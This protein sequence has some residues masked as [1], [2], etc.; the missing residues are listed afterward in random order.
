VQTI[1]LPPRTILAFNG[2]DFGKAILETI[3]FIKSH[4]EQL[5]NNR[6]IS[7]SSE[8]PTLWEAEHGY[9]DFALTLAKD[10]S[11]SNGAYLWEAEDA[12]GEKSNGTGKVRYALDVKETGSYIL[13]GRFLSPTSDDDSFFL[14]IVAEDGTKILSNVTWAV[15]VRTEWG[16]NQFTLPK[17]RKP[18]PIWLPKGRVTLI[19]QTREAGTKVDQLSLTPIAR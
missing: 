4:V 19:L 16:W 1:P 13:A 17:Q 7:V 2:T 15:G 3:P 6:A 8:K 10:K 11:A 5:T 14:T 18:E 9:F 12:P